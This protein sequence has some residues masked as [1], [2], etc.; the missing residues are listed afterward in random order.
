MPFGSFILLDFCSFST[1]RATRNTCGPDSQILLQG[2]WHYVAST[3]AWQQ[4]CFNL[5]SS[6]ISNKTCITER[7][8]RTETLVCCVFLSSGKSSSVKNLHLMVHY[9][10]QPIFRWPLVWSGWSMKSWSVDWSEYHY[11]Y[12]CLRD[13]SI[14]ESFFVSIIK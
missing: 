12:P 11:L 4:F 13:Y 5:R 14:V 8:S 7:V 9:N 10:Q 6:L 2:D 1:L 3:L